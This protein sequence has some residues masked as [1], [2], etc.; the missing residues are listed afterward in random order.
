M[1]GCPCGGT[2]DRRRACKCSPHDR[3]RY[4]ARVS[5]PVLD[6]IDIHVQI[7]P[8]EFDAIAGK[9]RARPEG[10]AAVLER[11][12]RARAIQRERCEG[13][14][15]GARM[16]APLNA[17]LTPEEIESFCALD[18]EGETLIRHAMEKLGLS[19]RGYHRVL[20]VARTIADLAGSNAITPG[21][22]AEA[23][24]YRAMERRGEAAS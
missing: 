18:R 8:V 5:G 19:A 17:R 16:T 6:R 24:Q 11:V 12:M 4:L 13:S 15:G 3:E 1:K 22:V 7:P 14:H 9:D 23:I 2:G 10:S 21:H 20:R